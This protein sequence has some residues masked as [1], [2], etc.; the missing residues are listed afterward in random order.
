MKPRNTE[1]ARLEADYLAR[2]K[3][4]IAGRGPSEVDEILD[5]LREHIG[6]EL[7]EIAEDQVSLVQMANVLERLG[8]PESYAEGEGI[9][10]T[11]AV[12]LE[13][14][15]DEARPRLSRLALA[16]ALCLPGAFLAT[17]LAIPLGGNTDVGV[18]CAGVVFFSLGVAGLVLGLAALVAVRNSRQRLH[19]RAFA[20]IGLLTL[21]L[22]LLWTS[23][24]Y[25]FWLKAG[26]EANRNFQ[27]AVQSE[28]LDH[29]RGVEPPLHAEH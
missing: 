12:S 11:E 8:S 29:D 14:R 13:R 21:P 26:H 1:A 10:S 27:R 22:L 3:V 15:P 17:G 20:W 18:V 7:S 24:S 25:M 23:A 4:A 2:V 28:N 5:S 16:A 9:A 19:G 6:E